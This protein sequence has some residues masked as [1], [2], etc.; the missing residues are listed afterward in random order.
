MTLSQLYSDNHLSRRKSPTD[1]IRWHG[2][3]VV[4]CPSATTPSGRWSLRDS[5]FRSL[6]GP[7]IKLWFAWK[8]RWLNVFVE[9][10]NWVELT[11]AVLKR[12]CV[13]TCTEAD[14]LEWIDSLHLPWSLPLFLVACYFTMYCPWQRGKSYLQDRVAYPWLAMPTRCQRKPHGWC[15]L[16]GEKHMVCGRSVTGDNLW[17]NNYWRWYHACW[18]LRTVLRYRQ[19]VENCG[20]SAGKTLIDLLW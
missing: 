3:V 19:L 11:P 8:P 12:E 10:S 2:H 16:S 6:A 13:S 17:H 20:R 15:S 18:C 4:A 7:G 14:L 1:H 9:G 5:S